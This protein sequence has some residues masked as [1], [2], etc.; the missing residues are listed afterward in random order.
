VTRRYIRYLAAT[1]DSFVGRLALEYLM[2][3]LRIAPVRLGSMTG[4]LSGRWE[5]YAQL[6]TSSMDGDFTNVVC[7]DPSRWSW[8]QNVPMLKRLPSG[9]LVLPGEVASGRQELYTE[10]VRNVL[11]TNEQYRTQLGKEQMAT[12]LRYEEIVTSSDAAHAAWRIARLHRSSPP[13]LIVVPVTDLPAL[14]S[15]LIP[16]RPRGTEP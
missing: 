11:L 2:G 9:A 3:I 7:C 16:A 8:V 6:L 15:V 13:H 14:R 10:G 12:G 5:S 1:D 4:G